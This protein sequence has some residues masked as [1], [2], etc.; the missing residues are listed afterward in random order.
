M[1]ASE[2]SVGAAGTG[3]A[4]G[5]AARGA[6]WGAARRPGPGGRRT[7][8]ALAVDAA[9]SKRSLRGLVDQLTGAQLG[10]DW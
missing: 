10:R 6:A 3:V 5:D 2:V 8:R 1:A 9:E 7:F 4:A